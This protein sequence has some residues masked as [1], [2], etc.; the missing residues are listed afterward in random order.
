MPLRQ[1]KFRI[2]HILEAIESVHSYTEGMDDDA[3]RADER[4]VD[5][6]IRKFAV[7]G[8]AARHVPAEVQKA[9]PHIPWRQMRAMRNL[10][11]HEY[12]RVDPDVVFETV[13]TDLP[14]VVVSLKKLLRDEPT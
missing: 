1:W 7:I 3:F 12:D 14:D 10:L 5:A 8:E 13:R 2:R 4:T 11:V 9:Y 6:V